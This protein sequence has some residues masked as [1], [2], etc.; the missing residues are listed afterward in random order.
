M[1]K[2]IVIDDHALFRIGL[3][4]ILKKD[5]RFNVVGEFSSFSAVRSH[6]PDLNAHLVLIDISL[7]KESGLDVAK[8]FKDKKPGVKVVILSSH[9]E[10]FYIVNAMEAGIDGYIHKDV[11]SE[12]LILG[13]H[14]VLQGEK[15]Y[16]LEISNLLVSSLYKKSYRGLPFLTSKEKEVVKYLIEGCSSKEIAARMEVSPRTIETHRANVLGKF[17][18]KNTTELVAKIAEQKIRF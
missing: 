10:E 18:L 9:K 5:P 14:K 17:D 15:F 1:V 7:D 13:L 12:E 8:Y 4:S 3:V 6:V 2:L 11:E 16:S